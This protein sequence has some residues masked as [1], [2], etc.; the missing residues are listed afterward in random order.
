MLR[1]VANRAHIHAFTSDWFAEGKPIE[2]D[3]EYVDD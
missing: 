1:G 3:F 2:M